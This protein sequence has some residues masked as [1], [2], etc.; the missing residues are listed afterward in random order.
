MAHYELQTGTVDAITLPAFGKATHYHAAELVGDDGAIAAVVLE[1]TARHEHRADWDETAFRDAIRST[2]RE[3]AYEGSDSY[4]IV[5]DPA[6]DQ[7]EAEL[8]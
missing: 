1:P 5:W 7:T 3:L 4:S 2:L 6:R 8:L